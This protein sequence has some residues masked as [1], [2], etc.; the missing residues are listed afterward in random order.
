MSATKKITRLTKTE[1]AERL[2]I[3]RGML[4]YQHKQPLIDQ[5]VKLQIES[6]WV[7]HP[8]YGHKRL[9][10]ALKLNKKRIRRVMKKFCL[11]PKRKRGK[12]PIKKDD[13]NKPASQYVN[14]IKDICPIA[15]DCIWVTDFTYIKYR[16]YFIYLA[17]MIDLFTREVVGWNIS[18][19]H[20]KELVLGALN[21]ALANPNHHIPDLHHSDQG[22]EYEAQEY[23]S[24]VESLNIKISMSRKASPWEN[25]YQ[26]SF[27]S[28]FK[29]DLGDPNRFNELGELIEAIHSTINYYNNDR[30]HTSIKMTPEQK[31]KQHYQQPSDSVFKKLGT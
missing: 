19:F 6:V 15:P 26:E 25:G 18:R 31:R 17:T 13:Q 28:Q 14:L 10:L 2:G 1:L 11:T 12:K 22:S 20:N 30:I 4:Y 7:N 29:L 9:A 21:H 16:H 3:S 24:T 5:E 23:I 8:S 27:Y